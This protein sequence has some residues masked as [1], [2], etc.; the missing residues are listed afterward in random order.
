[1]PPSPPNFFTNYVSFLVIVY[2]V[3]SLQRLQAHENFNHHHESLAIFGRS[4]AYSDIYGAENGSK[5]QAA[6]TAE[7]AIYL[8]V[9]SVHFTLHT[10]VLLLNRGV[11]LRASMSTYT[12]SHSFTSFL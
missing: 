7:P 2:Y 10:S 6:S 3:D 8:V 9:T 5:Y 12:Y 1:M 4:D 11:L